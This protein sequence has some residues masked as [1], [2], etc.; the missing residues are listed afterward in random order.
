MMTTKKFSE[1]LWAKVAKDLAEQTLS[2]HAM[3]SGHLVS[4]FKPVGTLIGVK[5]TD[6][7][8]IALA[9]RLEQ[10]GRDSG[11]FKFHTTGGQGD[12]DYQLITNWTT[13]DKSGGAMPGEVI[14]VGGPADCDDMHQQF[15]APV[16]AVVE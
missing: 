7:G 12:K 6:R 14:L 11:C 16:A 4:N 9:M 15:T 1:M 5:V 10:K 2:F 13:S 8:E 3:I